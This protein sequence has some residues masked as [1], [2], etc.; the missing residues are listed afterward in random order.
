MAEGNSV[1]QLLWIERPP[2]SA[3]NTT[4]IHQSRY[5][6]CAVA[7]QPL[8]GR[9]Q[10]DPS[11]SC[12]N[13]ERAPIVNVSTQQPFTTQ[14]CQPSIRVGMHGV[15]GLLVGGDTRTMTTSHPFVS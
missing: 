11:L 12:K 14:G 4:S 9:S 7:S 1:L 6:A 10:A 13:R 15:W 8:V 3:A 2:L 5:T